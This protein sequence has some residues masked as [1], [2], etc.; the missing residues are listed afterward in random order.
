MLKLPFRDGKS[1]QE[2][3]TR[4]EELEQADRSRGAARVYKKICG[5]DR[6]N[7]RWPRKQG[8]ALRRL[9]RNRQ[10]VQSYEQAIALHLGLS[11]Q[12]HALAL[13][14]LVL[15]IDPDHGEVRR[16]ARRL[17]ATSRTLSRDQ[18][19]RRTEPLAAENRIPQTEQGWPA[20]GDITSPV[21]DNLDVARAQAQ[22]IRDAASSGQGIASWSP[23]ETTPMVDLSSVLLDAFD[24]L[25]PT[26]ADE[27]DHAPL[28]ITTSAMDEPAD[29]DKMETLPVADNPYEHARDSLEDMAIIINLPPTESS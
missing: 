4:A 7:P 21:N 9:G 15:N 8:D 10:A 11:Q 25:E 12:R 27:E 3:A 6:E 23:P 2:L 18:D 29:E 1:I 14:H 19:R 13:C 22:A 16:I 17:Q 28:E 20:V 26:R 24:H 5:L